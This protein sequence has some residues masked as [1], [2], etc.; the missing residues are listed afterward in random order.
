[1]TFKILGLNGLLDPTKVK[2]GQARQPLTRFDR[3]K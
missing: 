3:V 2:L 1:M